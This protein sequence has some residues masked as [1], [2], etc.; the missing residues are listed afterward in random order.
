MN[1]YERDWTKIMTENYVNDLHDSDH[2]WWSIFYRN[3]ARL[4]GEEIL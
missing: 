4:R 2:F 1:R 3:H